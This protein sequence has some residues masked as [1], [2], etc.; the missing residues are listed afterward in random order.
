MVG[1]VYQNITLHSF[2]NHWLFADLK[3]PHALLHPNINISEGNKFRKA[4][5]S[6]FFS[7]LLIVSQTVS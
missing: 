6:Y 4:N 3:K 7:T 2:T 5:P 1:W